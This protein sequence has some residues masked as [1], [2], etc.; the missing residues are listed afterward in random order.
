MNENIITVTQR[1]KKEKN[2]NEKIYYFFSDKNK[3]TNILDNLSTSNLENKNLNIKND[4]IDLLKNAMEQSWEKENMLYGALGLTHPYEKPPVD[5]EN[6]S[7]EFSSQDKL[8]KELFNYLAGQN[9]KEFLTEMSTKDY[10]D[11]LYKDSFSL[12]SILEK[13]H[14]TKKGERKKKTLFQQMSYTKENIKKEELQSLLEESLG[15]GLTDEFKADIKTQIDNALTNKEYNAIAI[16]KLFKNGNTQTTYTYKKGNDE[17][18][19]QLK[20]EAGSY[21]S[22][23][24]VQGKIQGQ[25]I[26]D[27]FSELRGKIT[28]NTSENNSNEILQNLIKIIFQPLN[29]KYNN[30]E[31]EEDLQ[32]FKENVRPVLLNFFKNSL[33][34]YYSTNNKER[35]ERNKTPDDFVSFLFPHTQAG[36]QGTLG[37]QMLAAC[38][39]LKN[40][41][42]KIE[43]ISIKGQTLNERFQQAHVDIVV[44]ISGKKIGIQSK[45]YNTRK[46]MNKITF[47]DESYNIFGDSLIRY[48]KTNN[49]SNPEELIKFF[50]YSSLTQDENLV[51]NIEDILRP[52]YLN[53]AR[54]EDPTAI[55]DLKGVQNNFFTYNFG[56]VPLS[57]ILFFIIKQLKESK[58][59]KFFSIDDFTMPEK[60][61]VDENLV[62]YSY[63]ES[64]NIKKLSD[65]NIG[66]IEKR[67]INFVGIDLQLKNQWIQTKR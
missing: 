22:V 25:D 52:F 9:Y 47:Y 44:T 29:E 8:E 16:K 19:Y 21:F 5:N 64:D 26:I 15:E 10:I 18:K 32:T 2:T 65:K 4:L 39:H 41:N 27:V 62:L 31:K 14:I 7:I 55:D 58:D 24:V 3:I 56:L 38:L 23:T 63:K 67:D 50:R 59:K 51:N 17:I 60:G 12:T 53:F 54:I 37:E 46:I 6:F 57:G 20:I 45:Q 40:E 13:E 49:F 43:E 61:F 36:I 35:R 30:S 33:K 1:K 11:K 66:D 34:E 42:S 48:L 28:Q